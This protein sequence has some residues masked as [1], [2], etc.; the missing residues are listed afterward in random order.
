[1][2]D[3]LAITE[4]EAAG[5][6][7]LAALD[8][9]MARHFAGRAQ[10]A[11]SPDE[12][13]DLGRS[14]QRAARSYRQTLALKQR[15]ARE[16]ARMDREAPEPA[17][18]EEPHIPRDCRRIEARADEVR[19][20]LRRIIWAEHEPAEPL[21]DEEDDEAG[22][23]FDVLDRYLDKRSDRDN[24]FGLQP[25]DDDVIA[26]TRALRHCEAFAARWRDLPDPPP[27]ADID[28]PEAEPEPPAPDYGDW[29]PP[30]GHPPTWRGSG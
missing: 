6:S 30:P 24:G 8:L 4:A 26:V 2:L 10:A 14:Y 23:H 27:E 3:A 9:A 22:Y 13:N 16:I 15:L 11:E 29:S 17:R 1:M 12:A 25:L 5:L 28:R 21:E 19:T 18:P 20:A 7:E